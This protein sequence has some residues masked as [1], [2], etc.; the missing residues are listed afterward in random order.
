MTN[1]QQQASIFVLCEVELLSEFPSRIIA[2]GIARMSG[3][4]RGD[5]DDDDDV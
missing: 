1:N 4:R 2:N 5:D 3:Q